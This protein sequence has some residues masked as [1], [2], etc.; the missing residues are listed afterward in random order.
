MLK[1]IALAICFIGASAQ[2]SDCNVSWSCAPQ[3]VCQTC[4]V[5]VTTVPCCQKVTECCQKVCTVE[6]QDTCPTC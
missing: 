3:P 1:N 5:E 2:A 4:Q 6:C